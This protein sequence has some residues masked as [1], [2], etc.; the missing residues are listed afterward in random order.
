MQKNNPLIS[1]IMP[2]H[3]GEKY[4]SDA[5]KS[6]IAQTYQDWE[7][8]VIDDNSIDNSVNLIKSFIENDSRIKLLHNEKPTGFPATPRNLGIKQALGRYI[9][10][11]DCDDVWLPTKLE[12]QIKLFDESSSV[13]YSYYKKMD[14]SGSINESIVKSPSEVAFK[15]LLNGNCIG[16][17]TGIY[18]VEKVGKI[19]QKEKGHEDY[20]MWLEILQNGYMA[21][22]TET[23]EA[24]YRESK[25]ST[26]GNKLKAFS[27][28]W[29]IYRKELRLSFFESV[30]HFC[31]YAF[32]G[33]IK[34]IK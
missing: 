26:S 30:Y 7:L 8:L 21:K 34:F 14:E 10:F 2:C 20:I 28:T 23:V 19:Y 9:A 6:V 13:I 18:D 24:I 27:W 4:I 5:I 32:K 33:V 1:I 12:K 31:I 15:G 16:N 3:N 29:N 25:K 17:L 22:N 11:L